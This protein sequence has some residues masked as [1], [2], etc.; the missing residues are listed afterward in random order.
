MRKRG[1][2]RIMSWLLA[3]VASVGGTTVLR[4]S[5]NL[6]EVYTSIKQTVTNTCL[7][8]ASRLK[9]WALGK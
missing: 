5:I 2:Q 8:L 7:S 1:T 3:F 9:G 4:G 6:K